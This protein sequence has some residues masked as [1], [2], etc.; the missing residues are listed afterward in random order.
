MEMDMNMHMS[1]R[2][3]P[4]RYERRETLENYK[5]MHRTSHIKS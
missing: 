5:G 1:E 4:L 2:F 3:S